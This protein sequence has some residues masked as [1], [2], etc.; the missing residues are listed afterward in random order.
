[1]TVSFNSLFSE[2]IRKRGDLLDNRIPDEEMGVSCSVPESG[3][4]LKE[5]KTV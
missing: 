2:N 3:K 5:E 1:M 4:N